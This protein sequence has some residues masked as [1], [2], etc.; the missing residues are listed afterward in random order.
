MRQTRT[1]SSSNTSSVPIGLPF[2]SAS[3]IALLLTWPRATRARTWATTGTPVVWQTVAHTERPSRRDL[4]IEARSAARYNR[5][6]GPPDVP[7][8]RATGR[9]HVSEQRPEYVGAALSPRETRK[10]C[11]G[12]GSYV[13][14]LTAP[15]MLHAAFVRSPHAHAR[16]ARVDAAAASRAPGIAAVL[17][18]PALAALTAPLRIAPPIPGLSPMEMPTLPTAK[19]RFVGDPVACVIGEDRYRV[20]DACALVDVAYEPLV[21]VIDPERARDPGLP[22][23][24]ETIAANRAYHGVFAHG[25]VEAAMAAAD[26]V[27]EARFHQG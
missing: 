26:R 1:L 6:G 15:G 20:E 2:G 8:R 19:V 5:A 18:G 17:T 10:H 9:S 12:R 13:G 25:D 21:A 22:R 7:A 23:V 27:I 14:D 24:D 4:P 16:I 11:L 3:S